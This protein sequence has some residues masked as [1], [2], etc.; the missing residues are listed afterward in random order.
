MF[1][2]K[3][4]THVHPPYISPYIPPPHTSIPHPLPYLHMT[5]YHRVSSPRLGTQASQRWTRSPLFSGELKPEAGHRTPTGSRASRASRAEPLQTAESGGFGRGVCR[6]WGEGREVVRKA[7]RE[8]SGGVWF[9]CFVL[10]V[11]RHL[12]CLLDFWGGLSSKVIL[13]GC[14]V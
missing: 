4:F 7:R 10:V 11:L 3:P 5:P 1:I 8:V 9:G 2:S 12:V 6:R 13:L 14:I